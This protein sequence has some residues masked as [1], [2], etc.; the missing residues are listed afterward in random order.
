MD[1]LPVE[2]LSAIFCF[3]C[4]DGGYTGAS[5]SATSKRIR[6]LSRPYALQS[7]TLLSWTQIVA[8]SI[9]LRSR[10]RDAAQS[11]RP[12]YL[13]FRCRHLYMTDRRSACPSRVC[14]LDCNRDNLYSRYTGVVP[15][16]PTHA[17]HA[18]NILTLL[19]PQLRTLAILVFDGPH[20]SASL[21][22]V[23]TFPLL[24]ELAIPSSL[25]RTSNHTTSRGLRIPTLRRLHIQQNFAFDYEFVKQVSELAPALTHLRISA[26]ST[27]V[28]HSGDLIHNGVASLIGAGGLE[29]DRRGTFPITLQKL[30][31]QFRNED[32]DVSSTA[33]YASPLC[34]YRAAY[35]K[36]Q[37]QSMLSSLWRYI[38]DDSKRRIVVLRPD[39]HD[40]VKWQPSGCTT[41]TCTKTE[42][43]SNGGASGLWD[44]NDSHV[45]LAYGRHGHLDVGSDLGPRST[46]RSTLDPT[47]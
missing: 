9:F 14:T 34:A 2:L 38:R 45:L 25:L 46:S 19:G 28:C 1:T 41:P 20:A 6:A 21:E 40:G 15:G 44:F 16:T 8:F 13:P 35:F 23:L 10:H 39:A 4:T 36:A 12:P 42:R 29:G 3:A 7:I 32:C 18:Y 47:T 31:L 24:E 30:V 43:S 37:L 26:L 33:V 17:E 11:P 5:L 22:P 27:V